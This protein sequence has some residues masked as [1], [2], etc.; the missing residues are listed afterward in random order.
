MRRHTRWTSP[1]PPVDPRLSAEAVT[2]NVL[3]LEDRPLARRHRPLLTVTSSTIPRPVKE[4]FPCSSIPERCL[5]RAA[6]LLAGRT[7]P[8]GCAGVAPADGGNSVTYD[9][10]AR[11]C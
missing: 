5:C 1:Y 11:Q 4:P 9:G 8:R 10:P 2:E 3:S 6:V 7:P